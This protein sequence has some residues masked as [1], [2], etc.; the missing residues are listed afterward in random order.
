MQRPI[1]DAS[2]TALSPATHAGRVR[3]A[4]SWVLWVLIAWL[5]VVGTAAPVSAQ[6][7]EAV[8]HVVQQ[9]GAVTA[10][11]EALPRALFLGA[12]VFT[13]DRILTGA[14]AKVEIEFRDGSTLSVGADTDVRI[15][16][17]APE[18]REQG[19]LTLLLGIIRTGLSN[20]WSEGFEVRTRAAIASVRSTDWVTEAREDRTS[21]FVVDG[22]VAVTGTA[23]GSSVLLS[24]GDGTDVEAGG[25]PSPPK[26]WGSARVEDVL[27]RTRLP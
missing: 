8:G 21:V 6:Q 17:Y 5:F 24:A 10:L 3:F 2:S 27:A 12:S 4:L 26:Q 15:V 11:R 22:R 14:G 1:H 9:R 20:L 18:G 19:H 13:G 7:S 25:A 23:E 16:A